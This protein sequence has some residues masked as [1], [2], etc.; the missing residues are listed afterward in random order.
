MTG[1]V[2][3]QRYPDMIAK[4]H[5]TLRVICL[6]HIPR[7]RQASSAGDVPYLSHVAEISWH[8]SRVASPLPPDV[9]LS[10]EYQGDFST[11]NEVL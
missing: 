3:P 1:E 4:I 9:F 7:F 2:P 11:I 5:N 8:K 6:D 10:E